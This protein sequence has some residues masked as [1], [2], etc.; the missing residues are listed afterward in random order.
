[1]RIEPLEANWEVQWRDQELVVTHKTPG[2]E[3]FEA[4]VTPD[5]G[6]ER[7]QPFSFWVVP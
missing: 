1:V 3:T 7:R 2:L 6:E 5:N 4:I